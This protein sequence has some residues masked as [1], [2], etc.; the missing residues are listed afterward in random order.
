[1][2]RLD[3]LYTWDNSLSKSRGKEASRIVFVVF[4]SASHI[5]IP[6]SERICI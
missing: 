2:K 5:N 3:A 4:A 1:M 6:A